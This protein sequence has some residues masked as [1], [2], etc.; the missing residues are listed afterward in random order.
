MFF[1]KKD[2]ILTPTPDTIK[3]FLSRGVEMVYPSADFLASRL[4]SGK[5]QTLFLGID[6]TGPTLHLGHVIILKKLRDFQK[7]GHQ[8]ILLIGDFTG[9]IGDPTD[10]TATRKK[11]TRGEVLKNATLYKKQASKFVSFSGVNK[12]QL[13]YNSEWL[14]PMR[15]D[16]VLELAS[17]ITGDQL[18]KRDMFAKRLEEGKSTYLHELL[19][20]LLQGY[21]S[22][23][24]DVDGEIGGN[25]Q[26]FNM[27]VGRDLMKKL[28]NKEKFV[29]TM[30]LLVDTSGKKM[31]KTEG[32]IVALTDSPSEMYGKVMS[33]TDGMIV[34]GFELCTDVPTSEIG[35]IERS[36]ASGANPKEHKMHLAK[37][38]VTLLTSAKDAVVAEQSFISQFSRGEVPEDV[39]TVSV[40][41]GALLSEVLLS[42]GLIESKGEF[43]R[44]V[45]E[46]AVRN[47]S[48]DSV[49]ER[50]DTTVSEA[51]TVKVGK[52]RFL[53]IIL[54]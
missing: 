24:M 31:G 8:V 1:S 40:A 5:K 23:A 10:K 34:R 19:Y 17:N 52:R 45:E 29:M 51:M 38:V 41:S 35:A 22:V 14:S 44:L 37:A 21:D 9:M 33:W 6:P 11:L 28:K 20:P 46:K 49:I 30:K 47:L 48:N 50:F 2:T 7:M 36:L 53:K 54:K 26:T 16:E 4:T 25:D 12:T 42:A 13:R 3:D 39:K 32:N 18:M 43:K 27:L 15:F